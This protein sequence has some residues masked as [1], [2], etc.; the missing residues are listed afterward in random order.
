MALDIP[1]NIKALIKQDNL[2]KETQ[3]HLRL[4]FYDNE[5]DSLYPAEN[6]FPDAELY[7]ANLGETWLVIED[8]QILSESLTIEE[9]LCSD[10]YL[11][12]GACESSRFE[13]TVANIDEDVKNHWFTAELIIGDYKLAFGV[14]KVDDVEIQKD[15]RFKKLIA[16]DRMKEFDVDVSLWYKN[17]A[18]PMTL[19]DFRNSLLIYLGFSS[20]PV[21]LIND[22]MYVS[23]TNEDSII[24]GRK[25]IEAICEING[26]FG[27]FDRTGTFKYI[28]LGYGG[29]YPS[30]DIYP[31]DLGLYPGESA[32]PES[33]QATYKSLDYKEWIV[34]SI[35]RVSLINK[36]GELS[37]S[38]GVG[39]NEYFIRDNFL[40][41]GKQS[42]EL[43][44]VAENAYGNINGR[45]YLPAKLELWSLPYVEVGDLIDIEYSK[46]TVEMFVMHRTT[47]GIQAMMDTFESFGDQYQ[48]QKFGI[49]EDIE[50]IKNKVSKN[51]DEI[52]KNKDDIGRVDVYSQQT[53]KSLNNEV[54]RAKNAEGINAQAIFDE[55]SRAT[56]TENGLSSRI[57]DTAE[58]FERALTDTNTGLSSKITQ[59]AGEIRLELKNTQENLASSITLTAKEIRSEVNN[60]EKGLNSKITQTASSIRSEVSSIN[61]D[62]KRTLRSEILQTEKSITST[63]TSEING[64]KSSMSQIK[65]TADKINLVVSSSSSSSSLSLTSGMTSLISGQIKLSGFVTFS[66][67]ESKLK[68]NGTTTINGSNI[69][70]GRID[71]NLITSGGYKVFSNSGGSLYFGDGLSRVYIQA[72]KFRVQSPPNSLTRLPESSSVN[73]LNVAYTVNRIIELLKYYGFAS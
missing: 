54:T 20:D 16:Y 70:T 72:S 49:K 14:Y 2:T 44:K 65:Q 51:E 36:D 24:S 1:E 5:I 52:S 8:Q 33:V 15:K 30:E 41:Y 58:K 45:T 3:R 18:F 40:I 48:V 11:R 71:C 57:T 38:F 12:F 9:N 42:A 13:I 35:D 39:T 53:N 34:E 69:T 6:L 67:V 7:P 43:L 55:S 61:D 31:I 17:L 28:S 64:V 66:Q 21:S 32:D 50:N 25:V 37:A 19:K 68:G 22:T 62:T 56:K 10:E 29:L 26:V 63:I 60:V 46:G 47:K 73:I 27:T 59:T 23:K 4:S